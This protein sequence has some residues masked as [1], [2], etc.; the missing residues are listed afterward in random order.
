MKELNTYFIYSSHIFFGE[1]V[2]R[3]SERVKNILYV[4]FSER[5]KNII[6]IFLAYILTLYILHIYSLVKEFWGSVKRLNTYSI[7]TSMK[8]F[9]GSMKE[10][11]TYFIYSSVKEFWGS[12]KELKTYSIYSKHI[13]FSLRAAVGTGDLQSATKYYQGQKGDLQSG[14]LIL[15]AHIHYLFLFLIHIFSYNFKYEY[16]T[17]VTKNYQGQT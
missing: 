12:V 14:L 6:Y 3:L 1:R 7:Y 8:E 17:T 15:G 4:F 10:L 16:F 13:F 9:W 11:N 2:L 5:V